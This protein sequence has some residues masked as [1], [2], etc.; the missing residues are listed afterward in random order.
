MASEMDRLIELH[1]EHQTREI[2]P[3][4]EAAWLHHRFTQIHPFQDGNGRIARCLASLVFIRAGWFPL[5]LTRDDRSTYISALEDSDRGDL[6]NLINLF[7]K[8]QRQAFIRSLGLS[9]QILSET[10]ITQV[11]IASVADKLQ[12]KQSASI[13]E[14]CQKVEDFAAILFEIA[15]VSLESIAVEIK[16]SVENFVGDAEVFIVKSPVGDSRSYYHRYQIVET[17]KELKYFANLR[18]YHSWV[19]L[20]INVETSIIILL[21]FHVLGREYRG[22]LACYAC[23]YHKNNTEE[24]QYNISEIQVL[25]DTPFQFSYA[26]EEN[27]LRE[28]FGKWLEEVVVTGLEYWHKSF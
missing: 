4:V 10:R 22:L 27:N 15:S 12:K 3:E 5:V 8:S 16:R 20:V 17:A 26:D 18:N 2:P 9:E 11:I 25:A 19:Q 7:V 28:R 1:R 6:S 23:A 24:N 13:Q 21:S 14:K